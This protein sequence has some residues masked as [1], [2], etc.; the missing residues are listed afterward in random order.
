MSQEDQQPP[1]ARVG[2][3]SRLDS[4]VSSLHSGWRGRLVTLFF[5]AL[6]VIIIASV[7]V[8]NWESFRTF[9]WRIRPSWIAYGT[10]ALVLDL[11]LGAVGWHWLVARL[12]EQRRF[13]T[14][15]KF[16]CYAN[17]ARRIPGPIWYIGSRAVL[18]ETAGLP[19]ATTSLLSALELVMI[20]VSGIALFL[21]T[22]PFWV[23]PAAVRQQLHSSWFLL[24][25]V[26]ASLALVHPRVLNWLWARIGGRRPAQQL[27]W[28]DT[29]GWLIFYLGVWLIGAFT[30]FSAVNLVHP[31]PLSHF[32]DVAG[33]WA[34]AGAVSLAGTLTLTGIGLRELSLT[35]LLAS[36]VPAPVALVIAILLRVLW[37]LGELTGALLSLIL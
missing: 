12:T 24:L 21:L 6:S 10:A 18:Y 4:A 23:L 13:R 3:I 14:N 22:L 11:F 20:L 28:A 2:L 7:M 1:V 27:R 15:L 29:V 9:D 5:V 19:K 35:L 8:A 33:M 37:L 34:A 31:L 16:W 30:L 32:P 36:F 26:P 17:L 25:I